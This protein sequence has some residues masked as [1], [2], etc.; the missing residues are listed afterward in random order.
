VSGERTPIPKPV[1]HKIG[2]CATCGFTHESV[3]PYAAVDDGIKVLKMLCPKCR[4]EQQAREQRKVVCAYCGLTDG[5]A[6][7]PALIERLCFDSSDGEYQNTCNFFIPLCQR[8]R[9]IPHE[10]IRE[11][12]NPQIKEMCEACPDRFKCYTGKHNEPAHSI[13]DAAGMVK[14]VRTLRRHRRVW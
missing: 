10:I 9:K 5:E 6:V 11:K 12:L 7:F 2:W 8:C 4:K 14:N 1:K 13:T 3:K